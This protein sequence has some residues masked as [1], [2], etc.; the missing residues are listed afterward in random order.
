M[1]Y[2]K[3]SFDSEEEFQLA[4]SAVISARAQAFENWKAAVDPDEK[5]FYR[6]LMDRV[7][8]L[9]VKYD[10]VLIADKSQ[11]AEPDEEEA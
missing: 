5:A 10:A 4:R 11:D 1:A 9:L 2:G 6:N 8:H 7:D 3:I